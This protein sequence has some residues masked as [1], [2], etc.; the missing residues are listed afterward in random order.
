MGQ[1]PNKGTK[2]VK[3]LEGSIGVQLCDFGLGNGFLN[4]TLEAQA[5]KEKK[6]TWASLK[7]K[8]FLYQWSRK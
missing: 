5:T 8:P 2:M 1:R 6:I 4:M 3:L 7:L